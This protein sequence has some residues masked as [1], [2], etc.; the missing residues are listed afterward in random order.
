M[1][2]ALGASAI[3]TYQPLLEYNAHE[4]VKG[5]LAEPKHHL[6]YL[7]RYDLR[8]PLYLP[9]VKHHIRI[10]DPILTP[11]VRWFLGTPCCLRV[12]S[13]LEGRQV[14]VTRGGMCRYPF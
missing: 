2:Q 14:P 8:F 4:L 1:Q 5:I 10:I 3:R 12:P 9:L 6:D 13:Y 7:V 11:Q